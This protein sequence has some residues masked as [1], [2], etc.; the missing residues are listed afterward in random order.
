[1][2]A[3]EEGRQRG[4]GRRD[5]RRDAGGDLTSMLRVL[6]CVVLYAL[7]IVVALGVFGLV[8]FLVLS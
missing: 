3:F 8:V 2:I 4:E 1:M 5:A 6:C 7:C